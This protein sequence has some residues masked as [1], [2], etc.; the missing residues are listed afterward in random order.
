[1]ALCLNA[2]QDLD[3]L[4]KKARRLPAEKSRELFRKIF[5]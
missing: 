1:M 5:E 4:P 3:E 2:S